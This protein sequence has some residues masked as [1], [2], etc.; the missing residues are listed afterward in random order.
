[1]AKISLSTSLYLINPKSDQTSIDSHRNL[2]IQVTAPC[3][4]DFFV[5]DNYRRTGQGSKILAAIFEDLNIDAHKIAFDRP[6][7]ALKCLLMKT[8]GIN[9]LIVHPN[10]FA[11]SD[12]FL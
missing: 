12:E 5:R 11:V 3:L 1:M 2:Y 10:S 7:L 8:F 6:S 9:R 4:L